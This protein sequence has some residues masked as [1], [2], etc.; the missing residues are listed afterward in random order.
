MLDRMDSHPEEFC[1]ALHL[2]RP[3]YIDKWDMVLNAGEFNWVEKYLIKKK[4]KELKRS[5]TH[6]QILMTIMYGGEESEVPLKMSTT[7]RFTSPQHVE[8]IIKKWGNS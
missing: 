1:R 5:A 8:N 3:V 2:A 7:S 4:I 6:Q